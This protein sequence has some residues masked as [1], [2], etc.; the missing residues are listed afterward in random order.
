VIQFSFPRDRLA[1]GKGKQSH[2]DFTPSNRVLMPHT[3]L[4]QKHVRPA[5]YNGI[6][7]YYL[8]SFGTICIICRS[9]EIFNFTLFK[10]FF[11]FFPPTREGKSRIL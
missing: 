1:Q 3:S 4:Q 10:E 9:A 11:F 7:Y 2:K 5:D 6:P 8:G